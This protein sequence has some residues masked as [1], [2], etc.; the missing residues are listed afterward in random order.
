ME[1][2]IFNRADIRALAR[3]MIARGFCTGVKPVE[4]DISD[5]RS[6]H[7]AAIRYIDMITRPCPPYVELARSIGDYVVTR[8]GLQKTLIPG[9][10]VQNAIAAIMHEMYE[11]CSVK[12]VLYSQ[13]DNFE[14]REIEECNYA[15]E[16]IQSGDYEFV[17]DRAYELGIDACHLQID[18]E[19]QLQLT[20]NG[21]DQY[22]VKFRVYFGEIIIGEIE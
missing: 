9:A 1:P 16:Q 22:R 17:R 6:M 18:T 14:L 20:I 10:M 3:E 2:I 11:N 7:A 8:Q 19:N 15:F 12:P 13:Y 5:F 21:S 4:S